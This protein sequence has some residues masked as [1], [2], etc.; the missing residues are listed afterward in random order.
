MEPKDWYIPAR[1]TLGGVLLRSRLYA[2]AEKVFRA[3]LERNAR[4][5]RSLFGLVESLKGQGK[6]YDAQMV[7][8]EFQEAW[9]N[10]DTKL[11]VEDL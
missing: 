4:S 2:D 8:L 3:D 9:K 11:R 1:E 6:T 5:G 7:E 10:A